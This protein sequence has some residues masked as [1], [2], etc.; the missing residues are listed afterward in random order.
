MILKKK[1]FNR[2]WRQGLKLLFLRWWL[3]PTAIPVSN[4][5]PDWSNYF[6][7]KSSGFIYS[8]QLMQFESGYPFRP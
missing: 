6:V 3:S 2:S 5:S 4:Q 7:M 8:F 1:L